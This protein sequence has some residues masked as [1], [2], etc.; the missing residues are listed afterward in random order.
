MTG[1]ELLTL[2]ELACLL[3]TSV[4]AM[5]QIRRRGGGPRAVLL[6]RRLLFRVS[7]VEAWLDSLV[8][9]HDRQGSLTVVEGMGNRGTGSPRR[10]A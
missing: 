2:E 8:E 10:T 1:P 9:E 6:G 3:R 7:D 4:D 5:Y